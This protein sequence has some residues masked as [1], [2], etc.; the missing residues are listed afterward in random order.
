MESSQ[1]GLDL[2]IQYWS[3]QSPRGY[4]LGYAN[5]KTSDFVTLQTFKFIEATSA[6]VKECA[7]F[8]GWIYTE[9]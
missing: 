2:E 6:D 7:H 5:P 4:H 8:Y 1:E 9:L 3:D